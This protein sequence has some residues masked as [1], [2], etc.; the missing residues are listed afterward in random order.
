M[1]H[2]TENESSLSSLLLSCL[3]CLLLFRLL[4]SPCLCLSLSV[5]VWCGGLWCVVCDTLKTPVYAG[6]SRTCFFNM[7][8]WC[9]HT[10]GRFECIHGEGGRGEGREGKSSAS[11]FFIG[12]TSDFL[13]FLEH[14]NRT[15][16]SSLIANF[17][18]TKISHVAL[19]RAS[20]VHRK[21]PLDLTNFKFENTKEK[22][23]STSTH[24][25]TP[26]HPTTQPTTQP[27][28]RTCFGTFFWR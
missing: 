26:H 17:L 28:T 14:L 20:E 21:K 19:S 8:A 10:W 11:C 9:R 23:T 6:T 3:L 2:H 16:G 13:T 5:S 12:K 27:R 1:H 24:H 7:C 15:L 4:F 18:L 25:T 22:D